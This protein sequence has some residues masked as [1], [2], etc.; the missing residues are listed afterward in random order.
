MAARSAVT[1]AICRPAEPPFQLSKDYEL[2]SPLHELSIAQA[3]RLIQTGALSPVDLV[4]AFL[5]R[6]ARFDDGLHVYLTLA[7]DAARAQARQAQEEIAAGRWRGPLH[8]IPF[9]VK[10]NYYTKGL[11]TTAASRLMQDFVPDHSASAIEALER[12]GAILLGKLNTWEYGTGTGAVHFDLFAPPAANPWNADHFTGGSSSGSAAAV[13]A[14]MA[15]ATLGTDTGGSV[16]LPASACGVQGIKP[17]FGRISRH[18]ILP[19]CWSFDTPGPLAWTVEDCAL[20][21][22]VLS[23]LDPRDSGSADMA[24][25]DF[26]ADLGKGVAGLKIGVVTNLVADGE[27]VEDAIL[28]NLD[29]A[30]AA[31]AKA[32]A[33][34]RAIALPLPPAKYRS[35]TS[36]INWA[37]SFSIHEQDFLT[38]RAEM[39]LALRDKLTTGFMVRA[40]DYLAAQRRRRELTLATDALFCEVDLLLSPTTYRTAPRFDAPEAVQAFTTVN[41]T[42]PYNLTGHPAMSVRSGLAANGMPTAIQLAGRYFDEATV[43]RA[44]HSFETQMQAPMRRPSLH[45]GQ[46][47]QEEA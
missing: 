27:A 6:I 12:A 44:A 24:V 9:A 36:T 4:E 45:A 23:G 13:A 37:E 32:G 7:G 1:V 47:Q 31:F 25:P 3:S 22:N 46:N 41:A 26:T 28:T 14:G 29:D 17:T 16:R 10:D 18:G 30:A 35:V 39:G 33:D 11:R 20:L 42:S 21:L 8:G 34:V 19:N 15:M 5:A 40:A 2:T 43:L 38:R